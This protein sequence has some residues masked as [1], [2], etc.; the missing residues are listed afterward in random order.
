M[1]AQQYIGSINVPNLISG[2]MGKGLS[3]FNALQV[4]EVLGVENNGLA[5]WMPTT[6]L[7]VKT[8]QE[9]SMLMAIKLILDSADKNG[10][11]R[12][13]FSL[14]EAKSLVESLVGY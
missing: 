10:I 7:I 8:Y 4:C 6:E 2:L 14:L 3:Y 5:E 9:Q 11:S 1:K 12:N 13:Q